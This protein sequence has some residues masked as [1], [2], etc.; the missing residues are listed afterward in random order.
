[1]LN[2]S[3]NACD[4]TYGVT[5]QHTIRSWKTTFELEARMDSRRGYASSMMNQDEFLLNASIT[6][7]LM[8]G[9][10]TIK[11]EG[12][13]MLKPTLRNGL[14]GQCAG[15]KRNVDAHASQL[16]HDCPSYLPFGSKTEETLILRP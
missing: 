15:T 16:L 12:L 6:Q 14:F 4:Y 1:M 9:R 11:L 10:M 7:S 2:S 13:D 3:L 5:G 8:N